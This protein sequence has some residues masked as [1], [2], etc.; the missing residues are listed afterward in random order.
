MMGVD[1]E[2]HKTDDEYFYLSRGGDF[3]LINSLSTIHFL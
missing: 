2:K 3:F 1:H